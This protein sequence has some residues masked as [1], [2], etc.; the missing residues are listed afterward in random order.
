MITNP[1]LPTYTLDQW[2][3]RVRLDPWVAIARCPDK[4]MWYAREIG[5]SHM[6]ERVDQDGLWTREPAGYINLIKF[7]DAEY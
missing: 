6:I 7:A 4:Q 5:Q 3:T 1:P 2:K